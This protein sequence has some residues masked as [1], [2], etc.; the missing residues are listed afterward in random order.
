M[1]EAEGRVTIYE[2]TGDAPAAERHTHR[3]EDLRM[4]AKTVFGAALACI[5]LGIYGYLMW[6][7]ISVVGDGCD[8]ACQQKRFNP[9][10]ASALMTAGALVSGVIIAELAIT[11]PNET[12]GA[13]LLG[14][15]VSG[16]AVQGLKIIIYSYLGV[17]LAFGLA[18]FIVSLNNYESAHKPLLD[19]GSAWFGL[20][21]AAAYAYFGINRPDGTEEAVRAERFVERR[22]NV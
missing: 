18:A 10:M 5:L 16:T 13:R 17:W 2:A 8:L 15:G 9:G 22:G 12:P 14:N 1:T 19:A 21:I 11:R 4:S 7:A 3:E 20:A 6:V